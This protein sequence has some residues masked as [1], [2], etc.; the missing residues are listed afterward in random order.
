MKCPECKE[1]MRTKDTRQWRDLEKE[2]D[3][4][5]RRRVCLPCGYRVMTI[6]MPKDVWT[7]YT[8]QENASDE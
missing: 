3:W 8:E 4:V 2:F 6:E 7:K 1:V 5:E